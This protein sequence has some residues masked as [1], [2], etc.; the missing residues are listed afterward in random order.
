MGN[1][2]PLRRSNGQG[3]PYEYGEGVNLTNVKS[4]SGKILGIIG[5]ILLILLGIAN[6]ANSNSH[7]DMSVSVRTD[8]TRIM[9]TNDG[10]TDL[11]N[12][13]LTIN[14][15]YTY[16]SKTSIAPHETNYFWP[17]QFSDDK[18]FF[19]NSNIQRAKKLQIESDQ[20]LKIFNLQ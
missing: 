9:I 4:I 6:S 12:L 5:V 18:G 1:I 16:R 3:N 10:N 11:T 15:T 19:F 2:S 7:S 13:E 8:A 17:E 14:D 20:G